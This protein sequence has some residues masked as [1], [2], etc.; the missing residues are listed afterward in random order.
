[1]SQAPLCCGTSPEWLGVRWGAG[2]RWMG[3]KEGRHPNSEGC[4]EVGPLQT[5]EAQCLGLVHVRHSVVTMAQVES[6]CFAG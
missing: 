5:G 6:V 4:G 3:L 1:M 2:D